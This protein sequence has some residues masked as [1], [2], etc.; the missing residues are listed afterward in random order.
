MLGGAPIGEPVAWY[1]PFVMN[2]DAEI[3]QA[4]EDYRYGRL[5]EIP[6]E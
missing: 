4:F 6:A 1:G 2:T 3:R 5:G